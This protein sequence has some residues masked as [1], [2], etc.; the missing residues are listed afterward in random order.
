MIIETNIYA[1]PLPINSAFLTVPSNSF[2]EVIVRMGN[3][4]FRGSG[5]KIT[6]SQCIVSSKKKIFFVLLI[7]FFFFFSGWFQGCRLR[8][9][10]R[11]VQRRPVRRRKTPSQHVERRLLAFCFLLLIPAVLPS[12]V[13]FLRFLPL[14]LLLKDPAL[15]GKRFFDFLS[16]RKLFNFLGYM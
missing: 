6:E 15:S 5:R 10:V 3:D 14:P 12:P 7:N 11:R 4:Q 13:P 16:G 2:V 8:L 9:L 1:Q